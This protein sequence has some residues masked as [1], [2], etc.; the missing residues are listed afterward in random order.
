M[1]M[2][3]R[4]SGLLALIL[5]GLCVQ[6][7]FAGTIGITTSLS[8]TVKDNVIRV[9]VSVENTGDEAGYNLQAKIAVLDKEVLTEKIP[10]FP[11][12]KPIAFTE[13]LPITA[14]TEGTYPVIVTVY[15][16]DAKQYPLSALTSHVFTFGA[17]GKPTELVGTIGPVTL[18]KRTKLDLELTN[19]GDESI[20]AAV[21]F[22]LPRELSAEE[23]LKSAVISGRSSDKV[24]FAIKNLS[25]FP[26]S[27]YPIL[28]IIEY[29]TGGIHQTVIA[30]GTVT[31][32]DSKEIF[33]IDYSILGIGLVALII[34][35]IALERFRK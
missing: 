3:K 7:A 20:N 9:H 25:A 33:G 16:T 32:V 6:P 12:K 22:I 18:A 4:Q 35:F 19:I 31:V 26:G 8:T 21:R 28:S 2:I 17:A 11:L 10:D 27:I 34:V 30:Q 14:T 5:T 15:C 24:R 13:E 1:R 23:P 29:D